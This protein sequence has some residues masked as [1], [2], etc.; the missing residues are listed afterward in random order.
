MQVVTWAFV[1]YLFER[2]VNSLTGSLRDSMTYIYHTPT[3]GAHMGA[4]HFD[5][6]FIV[7]G[8]LAV[9]HRARYG[10]G[11]LDALWKI[12]QSFSEKW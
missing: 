5:Q 3:S 10:A 7:L 1:M 2:D 4:G 9:A 11:G 12:T 8:V 6:A